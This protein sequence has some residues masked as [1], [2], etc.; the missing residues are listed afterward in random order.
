MSSI[1]FPTC[2]LFNLVIY[3]SSLTDTCLPSYLSSPVHQ[4]SF[5]SFFLIL[6]YFSSFPD[7]WPP[8]SLLPSAVNIVVYPEQSLF[9]STRVSRPTRFLCIS[10]TIFILLFLILCPLLL[11]FFIPQNFYS[12]LFSTLIVSMVLLILVVL[13]RFSFNIVSGHIFT[14]TLPVSVSLFFFVFVFFFHH[15]PSLYFA[16]VPLLHSPPIPSLSFPCP[17]SPL[18]L[19][20]FPSLSLLST[21]SSSL[22]LVLILLLVLSV[23]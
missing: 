1:L 3:F 13:L 11:R 17:R 4:Y 20:P 6:L 23:S 9:P 8:S 19:L 7:A 5:V 18:I 2:F 22:S 12:S 16:V 10:F 21:V 15:H 14:F